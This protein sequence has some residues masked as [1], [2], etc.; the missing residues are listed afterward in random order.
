MKSYQKPPV[1]PESWAAERR[2]KAS[3]LHYTPKTTREMTD[4]ALYRYWKKWHDDK[5]AG[6]LSGLSTESVRTL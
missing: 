3:D 2:Q 5:R 1:D 4:R 6:T